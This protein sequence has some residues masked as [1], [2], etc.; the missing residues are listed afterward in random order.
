LNHVNNNVYVK[1]FEKARF[2]WY[3]KIGLNFESLLGDGLGTTQ[4]RNIFKEAR[5]GDILVVETI[6]YRLGNSSFTLK[7]MIINQHKEVITEAET[8]KVLIDL[9][10]RKSIPLIGKIT[11][12]FKISKLDKK[13]ME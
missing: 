13:G 9:E 5:L 2:D 1:Y 7:Q 10:K 6:P 11:E 4:S 8:V 3:E 12:Q